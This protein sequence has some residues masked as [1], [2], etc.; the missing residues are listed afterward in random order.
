MSGDVETEEGGRVRIGLDPD[1]H[2]MLR[3]IAV[4]RRPRRS[5][6]DI[7]NALIR[8]VIQAAHAAEVGGQPP[9]PPPAPPPAPPR[10]RKP[11]PA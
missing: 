6:P 9:P 11:P 5:L 10:R 3:E 1:L 8:Q 2:Q 7:M 4:R